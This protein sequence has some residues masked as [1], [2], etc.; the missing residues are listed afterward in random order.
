MYEN[1][2]PEVVTITPEMAAEFL[3]MNTHNRHE[4]K[5]SI[6]TY[7]ESMRAG[8]WMLNGEPIIISNTN[9]ILDGQNR[10]YAC[11]KA[12]VPFETL[13]VWGI[14]EEA[15]KTINIGKTRTPGDILFID[16]IKNANVVAASITRYF[17]LD[18]NRA[19][20]IGDNT[21]YYSGIQLSS[22]GRGKGDVLDFYRA[23]EAVCERVGEHINSLGK[24]GRMVMNGSTIGGYELY[25][26]LG[27]HH[28]ESVVRSFF[29]QLATGKNIE[30]NTILLLRDALIMHRM[31]QKALT[32]RQRTAYFAKTW[33]AYISGRELKILNY[34][35]EREGKI[36]LL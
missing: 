13:M 34:S 19:S 21:T 4:D 20:D 17:I 2:K 32:G 6:T 33:N 3:K 12:G 36:E 15:F 26:I 35:A 11:V 9:V 31:R 29:E 14:T 24:S 22:L 18:S 5:R 16:N 27:K 28:P 23:N 25:L 10:L 7:A 8:K 1:I 30:N